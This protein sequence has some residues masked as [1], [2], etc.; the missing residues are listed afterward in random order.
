MSSGRS[1]SQ[2]RCKPSWVSTRQEAVVELLVGSA[3]VIELS[4][5]PLVAVEPNA[6]VE[7]RIRRELDEAQAGVAI[8]DVEVVL[9]DVERAAVEREYRRLAI[10]ALLM[11]A[12]ILLI[13]AEH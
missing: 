3:T 13:N 4:F 1:E 10:A 12:P 9:V 2:V 11:R 7:R 8:E 6:D 5:R